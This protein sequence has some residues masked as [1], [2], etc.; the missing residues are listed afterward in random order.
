M[1]RRPSYS[2]FVVLIDYGK[3]GI[4]AIVD[5]EITRRGVIERLKSG[6]YKNVLHIDHVCDGLV[7]DVTFEL[8]DEA[9][10]FLAQEAA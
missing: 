8:I 9:E 5:P 4:E 7:D 1:R 3:R 2:Y 10:Q 6:E